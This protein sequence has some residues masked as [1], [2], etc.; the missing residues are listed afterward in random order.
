MFVGNSMSDDNPNDG[1]FTFSIRLLGNEV[2][3]ASITADPLRS[4]WVSAA[5]LVTLLFILFIAF[6]GE[7]LGDA[8]NS[9]REPTQAI[10]TE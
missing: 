6:F 4:R 9:W 8:V 1:E 5:A 7:P 10:E 3:A 2:F